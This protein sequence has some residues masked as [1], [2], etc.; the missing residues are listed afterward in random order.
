MKRLAMILMGALLATAC[1]NAGEE[2]QESETQVNETEQTSP[3][4]QETD[5]AEEVEVEEKMVSLEVKTTGET[6]TTM[7]YKPNRLTV[8]AGAEV[9][10]TL[11]NSAS[12]EAMIHN[13][14]FIERGKQ[15]QVSQA[16]LAAGKENG[17]LPEDSQYI[18]AASDLA[19]PGETVDLTFTA[20]E[21]PGTYQFICTYPGHTAMKGV[22][23]VK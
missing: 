13:I 3:A 2:P 1:G 22:L 4:A 7:A 23:I 15:D 16:G 5:A 19:Y 6:M 11:T 10:L 14:V 8:P 21:S 18:V 20:P 12:A 17:F 9:K